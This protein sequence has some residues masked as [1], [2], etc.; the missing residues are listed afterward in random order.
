MQAELS[1]LVLRVGVQF[2]QV[3]TC[4]LSALGTLKFSPKLQV[5]S[6]DRTLL[7][8]KE[9]KSALE[10]PKALDRGRLKLQQNGH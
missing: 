1:T 5:I 9:R 10:E 4:A 3:C 7:E 8:K 2:P 6:Q